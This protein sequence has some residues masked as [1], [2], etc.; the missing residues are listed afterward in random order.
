MNTDI[1]KGK[2]T[3]LKGKTKAQWGKLTDD[4]LDY[5]EGNAQY[6]AGRVQERYGI[7]KDAAEKQVRDY[8]DALRKEDSDFR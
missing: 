2:W 1:I 4:D 6:L 5:A 7:E 3:Q 8:E